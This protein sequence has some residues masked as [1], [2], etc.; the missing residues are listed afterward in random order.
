MNKTYFILVLFT[1][2]ACGQK[3]GNNNLLNPPQEVSRTWVGPEFWTN[4]LQDW[5]LKDGWLLCN[6]SAP[7]RNIQIL[8]KQLDNGSGDF[9]MRVDLRNLQEGKE[10]FKNGWIGFRAGIKGEFD[11]Y[12]DN[13][14]YGKGIDFGI[15]NNGNLFIGDPSQAST[16]LTSYHNEEIRLELSGVSSQ[17]KYEVLLKAFTKSNELLAEVKTDTIAGEKLAGN[18][19]L[20]SHY[21]AKAGKK[22]NQT[23]SA[24]FRNWEI[25]GAK[26]VDLPEQTFGPILFCQYT[27]S[28]KILKLTAQ[29]PPVGDQ[30]GQEVAFQIK[31]GK[32]WETIATAAIHHLAR[33]APFKITDWD[34]TKDTPYRLKYELYEQGGL[35]PYY[36]EGTVRRDPINKENIKIAAFTGNNDLGFPNNDLYGNVKKHDPDMMFF[37]GDQ[38]YEG[39]AGYG[40]QRA[41]LEKASLDYLRKWYLYG[42]VFGDLMKDR[43]TIAI[44]DDHDVYHG[45]IW[46]EAGKATIREG[47]GF[48]QQDDGGYK[49]PAE[50][51]NMV[52]MTQTSHLPDPFDPTPVKQNIGVYYCDMN[53]GGISFAVIED[54]KFK[55]A[56]KAILPKGQIHNGWPQNRDFDA[57]TEADVPGAK[58]LGERQLNFLNQWSADWSNRT[59]MKV[60]LSQTIFANVA[61]LPS[62]EIHD[63]IVPRLRILEPGEY[64]EDDYPVS[65]M[66]SNGW[67]QTGRDNALRAIRK[68]FTFH[69]AGDQHLGST[70]QYGID[71]YGDA[72]FAICVPSVSNVWPRRWY[73][74]SKAENWKEGMPRYAGNF[75]DGFGNKMTVHAVSNPY[76]TGRKPSRLYDRATGYGIVEINRTTRD[77]SMANWPRDID[78]T[79][80]G[81]KPYEGWPI[82]VNQMDNYSRKAQ[83]YLPKIE[84]SGLTQPPVV[85]ITDNATGDIVYT[86]RA[87]DHT[88][89]PVVFKEGTY[90]IEVGD[91]DQEMRSFE[92][93]ASSS[94]VTDEVIKVEF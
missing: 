66:D 91:P 12:R 19:A 61:T 63:K 87:I 32:D 77:I 79:V 21:E 9:A 37:S 81:A 43:P 18:M 54:R 62:G 78:P 69:I 28:K 47:S 85:Q 3:E 72:G 22:P 38:I 83:A 41:P 80:E 58:L 16:P 17:G 30:D 2:V 26:V 60:L 73:P 48:E 4:P 42:W 27:L 33:T 70:I 44:P 93:I 45:N 7:N 84:V 36:F 65:D 68:G 8:T 31:K 50:W 51:V 74:S 39:V 53:Y 59:F 29:M 75:E 1:I 5:E 23:S 20:V 25:S 86:V 34:D 15:T 49:M 46:G 52:Q 71:K 13:A 40:V 90:T 6:T 35:K 92:G 24:Q 76:F 88:F 67:P 14:I 11:D 64:A 89:S 94:N 82:V 10:D 55:S 56:P 57:K